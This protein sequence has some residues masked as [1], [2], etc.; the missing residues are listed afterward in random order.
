MS[1]AERAI[2]DYLDGR[3]GD[4]PDYLRLDAVMRKLADRPPEELSAACERHGLGPC[5][6]TVLRR[7]LRAERLARHP[8]AE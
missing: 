1:E 7:W 2:D 6:L 5:Q 3:A 4:K 8:Q